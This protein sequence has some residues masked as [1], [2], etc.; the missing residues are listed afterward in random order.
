MS[1]SNVNGP[2]EPVLKIQLYAL[3]PVKSRLPMVL[4]HPAW[5][6]ASQGSGLNRRKPFHPY[7]HHTIVPVATISPTTAAIF[8][9][10]TAISVN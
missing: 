6:S 1:S 9:P 4:R 8:T 7:R 3:V 10:I 2:P 5:W